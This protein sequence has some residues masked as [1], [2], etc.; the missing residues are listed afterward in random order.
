MSHIWTVAPVALVT[1]A[2]LAPP[3]RPRSAASVGFWL[4]YLVNEFPFFAFCWLVASTLLALGSES[5]GSPAGLAVLAL[6]GLTASGLALI[7]WRALL[8]GPVVA[9]ALT[10]DLG[11]GGLTG[12]SAGWPAGRRVPAR[13]VFWPLPLRAARRAANREPI[14]YGPAG[15]RNRLDLYRHRS[16]PAGAPVL[17]HFHGGHFRMGGKSREARALFYRLASHGLG[18]HQRGLSAP[19]GGALSRIAGRCQARDCVGAPTRGR[20]RRRSLAVGRGGKLRGR[21]S[22]VDGRADGERPGVPARL[23]ACRHVGQRRRLPVRL[24]REPRPRGASAV[25]AARLHS[26]RRASV[27]R[28]AWRQRHLHPRRV[29]PRASS[30]RSAASR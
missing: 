22:G 7:M 15:R 30:R 19:S 26:P 25:I 21:A 8:A 20:V 18:V 10:R 29:G 2:A 5:L 9:R 23:R 6:A 14:S 28:R 1:L 13:T 27:L 11:L 17:I 24:L 4:G 3:R 12:Q 16:R